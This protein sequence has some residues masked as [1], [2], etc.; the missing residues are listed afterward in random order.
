MVAK[1]DN[2]KITLVIVNHKETSY[3]ISHKDM[4]AILTTSTNTIEYN[5]TQEWLKYL[6]IYK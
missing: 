6:H 1:E 5:P 2:N 3:Q 4:H